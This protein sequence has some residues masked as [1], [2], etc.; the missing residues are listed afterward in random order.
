M[1]NTVVTVCCTYIYIYIYIYKVSEWHLPVNIKKK[2]HSMYLGMC[3]SRLTYIY[4]YIIIYVLAEIL[5]HWLQLNCI[6]GLC[7]PAI[8]TLR[9]LHIAL[10]CWV[11]V[12]KELSVKLSECMGC[13][14]IH[15]FVF[16]SCGCI[17]IC[18]VVFISMWLVIFIFMW[19]YLYP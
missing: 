16:I 13:I 2:K 15:V 14:Y 3:L 19:L 9:V 4:I 8:P 10:K 1:Y 11:G 18:V 6:G 7:F 12:S 5:V 17:Y